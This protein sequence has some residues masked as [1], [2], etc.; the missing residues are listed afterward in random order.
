MSRDYLL[1]LDDIAEA[2]R[3]VA[4]YVAGMSEDQFVADEKTFD[5]VIRN[6]IIIGE[7]AKEPPG[8]R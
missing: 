7:A 2:C 1:F 5:A 4:G 8:R 6:L 3:K